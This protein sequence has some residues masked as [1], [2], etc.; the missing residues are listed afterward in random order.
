MSLLHILAGIRTPVL[1]YIA[2]FFSSL[3]GEIIFLCAISVIFWCFSKTAAYKLMFS[4][5]IFAPVT[6]IINLILRVPYPWAQDSS[7]TPLGL[8]STRLTGYSMPS[9]GLFTI[10]LL[11]IGIL[12]NNSN[13]IVKISCIAVSVISTFSYLYL[14]LCN[15][16]SALISIAI[17]VAAAILFTVFVN[18]MQFDISRYHVYLMISSIPMLVMVCMAV[19]LYLNGVITLNALSVNIS[20]AGM[21]VG[22]LFSW[23]FESNFINFNIRCTRAYKQF[24]KALIG[25]GS[26]VI[27]YAA[28]SIAFSFI[29]GFW[30][31]AFICNL[32]TSVGSFGAYPLFIQSIF[33]SNYN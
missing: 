5:V 1:D 21:L 8:F 9:L 24:L 16:L 27:T 22:L 10:I 20:L 26:T 14:G 19:S 4:Y 25:T 3:G 23:Y 17:A 28:L 18:S 2:L 6:C 32:I 33:A 15:A 12:V 30:A 31:S 13:V 7:L 29:P 11:C